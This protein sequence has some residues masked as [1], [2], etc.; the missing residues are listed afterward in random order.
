[1]AHIEKRGKNSWRLVVTVGYT[2]EGTPIR[3][4]KTIKAKNKTEAAKKLTIFESSILSGEYVKP[5]SMTVEK[6]FNE[7]K[8]YITDDDLSVR[9]KSSYEGIINKRIIPLYGN[10]MI[11]DVKPINVL[12]FVNNLKKDGARLDGKP[13]P[14]S[15]SSINNC[16]KAFNHLFEF[17]KNMLWIDKN[18]TDNVKPPKTVHEK[19][20]IYSPEELSSLVKGLDKLEIDFTMRTLIAIA[21]ASSARQGEIVALEE[22]NIDFERNGIH[23]KQ[24]LAVKKGDGVVL[25]GTKTDRVR[26]LPLP[27]EV[28]KKIKKLLHI[29]KQEDFKAGNHRVWKDHLFLFAD[30]FGKPVR[31]DSI[32]QWWTRFMNSD[33]FKT[34][35]LKRIRFHDLRHSSL[36]YLSSRGLRPKAVQERAG[37][38]RIDTTFDFYGH[39]LP[40]EDL[41]AANYMGEIFGSEN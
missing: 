39:V 26:F 22:K 28:M 14:L 10:M 17:A 4:R 29:R 5:E 6:L 16:Y 1:M 20:E 11:G 25:K 12:S 21:L 33:R 2:I 27:L 31:P 40:E 8:K 35:G 23:I 3:E 7:W 24:S 36:T 30:E 18:P 41:E 32:S 37:H 15:T 34:L 9:T 13:G 38:A 19:N